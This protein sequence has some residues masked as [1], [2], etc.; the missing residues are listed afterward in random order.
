LYF[1]AIFLAGCI[2]YHP[3]ERAAVVVF[4]DLAK[5]V[6]IRF[7]L[8]GN[9]A[10]E[11]SIIA[12]EFKYIFEYE[13]DPN[14][15]VELPQMLTDMQIDVPPDCQISLTRGELTD[16]FIR[17][18]EGRRTWDLYISEAFVKQHGC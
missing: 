5:T 13:E 2:S 3:T 11:E 1:A 12:G 16:L 4:N 18:P 15:P 17:D 10:P 14:K 7:T 6:K 9:Q 8:S